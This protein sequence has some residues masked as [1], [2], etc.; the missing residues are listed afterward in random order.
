[1]NDDKHNNARV[2]ACTIMLIVTTAGWMISITFMMAGQHA[3]ETR[4]NDVSQIVVKLSDSVI[5]L[6]KLVVSQQE[7]ISSLGEV[8]IAQ[9]KAASKTNDNVNHIIGILEISKNVDESQNRTIAILAE[10]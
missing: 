9:Q 1:M 6:N 4:V 5:D 3:L 7:V 8:V 10:R 2:D